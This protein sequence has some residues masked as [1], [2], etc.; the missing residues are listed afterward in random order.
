VTI[1]F[2]I[3]PIHIRASRRLCQNG[4]VIV[5]KNLVANFS[6]LLKQ[7]ISR[8]CRK[9]MR[10][11]TAPQ[12]QNLSRYRKQ[13]AMLKRAV[14]GLEKRLKVVERGAGRRG[15]SAAA[16]T[17]DETS[18]PRFSPAWVKKHRGKLGISAADYGKLVGVSA[19][20]IYNWEKGSSS[21][22]TKQLVSWGEVRALGKREVMARLESLG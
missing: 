5:R 19:L 15:Q 1:D 12:K 14:A 8:L 10:S 2:P 20:T 6:S 3:D 7:E 9:E 17:G 13:I 18:V 21:P 22:R 16:L 11:M 4:L